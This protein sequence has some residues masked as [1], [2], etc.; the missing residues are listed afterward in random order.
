MEG[1]IVDTAPNAALFSRPAA[2]ALRQRSQQ[3]AMVVRHELVL[4]A[5]GAAR[6]SPVGL[7]SNHAG[8]VPPCSALSA[9]LRHLASI[10]QE[11]VGQIAT[12]SSRIWVFGTSPLLLHL[13]RHRS[14]GETAPSQAHIALEEMVG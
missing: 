4:I 11:L 7:V 8:S 13:V 6:R 2:V 12:A 3:V 1:V 14:C 10:D 9:L 5:E